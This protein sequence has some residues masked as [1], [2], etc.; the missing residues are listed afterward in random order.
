MHN[1]PQSGVA[2]IVSPTAV[3]SMRCWIGIAIVEHSEHYSWCNKT[4]SSNKL[5]LC[6]ELQHAATLINPHEVSKYATC[7]LQHAQPPSHVASD[8]APRDRKCGTNKAH[9][10]WDMHGARYGSEIQGPGALRTR[11]KAK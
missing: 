4:F 6:D 1:N 2:I 8:L 9:A 11:K 5:R 3:V 7:S 10:V